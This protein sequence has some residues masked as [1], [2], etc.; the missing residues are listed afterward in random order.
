MAPDDRRYTRSHEWIRIEGHDALV[1]ITEH[2][3]EQL[4][5]VTFVELPV[6]GQKLRSGQPFGS[7]ESV[8]AVSDLNAPLDGEVVAA[9]D[10][11]ESEPELVNADPF[12][13]GWLIRVSVADPAQAEGLLT[14]AEY[15]AFL[16]EEE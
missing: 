2:A 7:I 8:K 12:G 1:G 6:P 16:S 3:A 4:G 15:E 13:N 11:L 5:D 14:A 10:A 9:N